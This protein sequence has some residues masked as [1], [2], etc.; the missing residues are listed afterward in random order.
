VRSN[1]CEC[2]AKSSVAGVSGDLLRGDLLGREVFISLVRD[3]TNEGMPNVTV[4][5]GP[6]DNGDMLVSRLLGGIAHHGHADQQLLLGSRETNCAAIQPSRAMGDQVLQRCQ[7]DFKCRLDGNRPMNVYFSHQSDGLCHTF[8]FFADAGR[9]RWKW[10][11]EYTWS[12][13]GDC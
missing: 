7:G 3:Q 5:S 2:C 9:V 8:S 11:E 4:R 1:C 6:M 12:R 10:L 13:A